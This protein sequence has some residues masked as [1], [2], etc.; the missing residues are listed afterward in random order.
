M[1]QQGRMF[2]LWPKDAPLPNTAGAKAGK[3][4]N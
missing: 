2:L 1:R 4:D 3:P